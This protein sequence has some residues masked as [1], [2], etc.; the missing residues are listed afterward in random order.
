MDN[1]TTAAPSQPDT[2]TAS[3]PTTL[4]ELPREEKEL[5]SVYRRA[6]RMGFADI[7]IS[8]QEGRRVKLW[9]TEKLR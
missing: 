4:Q 6:K 7:N 8:I 1:G 3:E 5:L 9:L 2:K